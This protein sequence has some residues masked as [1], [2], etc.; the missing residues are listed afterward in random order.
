[1]TTGTTIRKGTEGGREKGTYRVQRMFTVR[2]RKV[3]NKQPPVKTDRTRERFVP[4]GRRKEVPEES[5]SEVVGGA[6]N[7]R[8]YKK[9]GEV[10]L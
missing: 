4:K 3:G 8:R 9:G 10:F 2:K 5:D 1:M 7:R 6:R